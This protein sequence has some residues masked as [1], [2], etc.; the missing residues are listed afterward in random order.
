M[1]ELPPIA[2]DHCGDR[3]SFDVES[4]PFTVEIISTTEDYLRLLHGVFD[5]PRIARLFAR[6]DF[7]FY[8]DAIN[9]VSGAYAK[10]I[11]HDLLG[12]PLSSL[13]NC[14]P[15]PVRFRVPFSP[16]FRRLSSGP[17]LDVRDG[18]GGGDGRR[19]RG[20]SAG[21]YGRRSGLRLCDGRRRG[22]RDDSGKPVLRESVGLARDGRGEL[23]LR[24]VLREWFDCIGGLFLAHRR[25]RGPCRRPPRLTWWRR[26]GDSADLRCRRDGSSS[27]T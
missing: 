2:I 3:F 24:A 10:P 12:A 20:R 1:A 21:S 13:H 27:G 11:F 25:S 15:K 9:G 4:S 5:F 17:Q 6:R 18:A 22:P 19:P 8:F 14:E 16:G 23:S 26:S 7:H